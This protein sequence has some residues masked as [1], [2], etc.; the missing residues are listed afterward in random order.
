MILALLSAGLFSSGMSAQTKCDSLHIISIQ[1]APLIDSFI[2]VIVQ[3]E[4]ADIFDYPGFILYNQL[5]DTVARETVNYFG[6]GTYPQSHIL[7]IRPGMQATD[8][9]S[10]NLQLWSGFFSTLECTYQVQVSLCPDTCFW[11]YTSLGN[12]GG[13]L[14]VDTFNWQVRDDSANIVSSG[15]FILSDTVQMAEDSVCLWPGNY[16]LEIASNFQGGGQLYYGI[17]TKYYSFGSIQIPFQLPSA[18]INFQ[19]FKRCFQIPSGFTELIINENILMTYY[20]LQVKL[21]HL[22]GLPLGNMMVSDLTGRKLYAE[23]IHESEFELNLGGFSS[24]L[25][26]ITIQSEGYLTSWKIVHTR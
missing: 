14:V 24:G 3:N 18:S 17:R 2:E 9:F 5:G 6:I 8:T 7:K 22:K 20:H 1:Y 11:L 12:F 19:L 21:R 16:S 26:I 15:V 25:Y 13:A 4:S 23:G 10:G